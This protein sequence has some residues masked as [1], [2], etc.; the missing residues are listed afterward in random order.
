MQY[1]PA[2][3]NLQLNIKKNCNFILNQL[4]LLI[5]T[6]TMPDTYYNKENKISEAIKSLDS[7]KKPNIAKT[8]C[9]FHV[10]LSRLKN[11]WNN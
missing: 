10:P 8:T 1:R 4:S 9:D 5:T 2:K 7:Q 6:T 3:R 11:C